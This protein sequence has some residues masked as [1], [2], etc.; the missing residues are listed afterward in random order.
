MSNVTAFSRK[1]LL[2]YLVTYYS[3]HPFQSSISASEL[4]IL[5][6]LDLF[7]LIATYIEREIYTVI[8][9]IE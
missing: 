8:L 6:S 9:D 2:V 3:A 5:N 7:L 1:L 4:D